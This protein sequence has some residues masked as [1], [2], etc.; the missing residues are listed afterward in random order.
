VVNVVNMVNMVNMVNVGN[1]SKRYCKRSV[2]SIGYTV[3]K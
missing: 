2:P 1:L 3:Y